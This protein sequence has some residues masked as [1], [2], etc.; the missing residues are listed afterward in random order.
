MAMVRLIATGGTIASHYD[1]ADAA[2]TASPDAAVFARLGRE[3][4][5]EIDLSAEDYLGLGSYMLSLKM[6]FELAQKIAAA[7]ASDEVDGVVVTHGTDTLEESAFMTDLVVGSAKPVVFTG[8]Q[9][10]ADDLDADGP[11]NISDA[12]RVAASPAARCLGTLV[13]F[14]GEIHAARDVTKTHTSRLDTFKSP[15]HGRLGQI[16]GDKVMVHR[17]IRR[18]PALAAAG[19]EERVDLVK[20]V[21]GADGRFIDCARETGARA[22]VVEAFGRGNVT[23][24]VLEACGRA[25]EAGLLVVIASRCAMG[26]VAP[27]YGGSGGAALVRQG[28]LFAG[29]LSGIK[30]RILLALLLAADCSRERLVATL[31]D[32]AA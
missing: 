18:R 7:V 12:V 13:V 29:D 9:R 8:A 6:G 17:L 31:A 32:H 25:H 26:R 30:T 24:A 16:D 27:L 10:P 5:P 11:R 1:P 28:S 23:P 15:E 2:F 3:R 22:V 19:V 20:L 14:D 21:M 4:F